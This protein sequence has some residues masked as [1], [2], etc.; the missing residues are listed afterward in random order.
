MTIDIHYTCDLDL[1]ISA[2]YTFIRLP[3]MAVTCLHKKI[4]SKLI[5]Q[6]NFIVINQVEGFESSFLIA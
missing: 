5:L 6:F 3:L 1:T 2:S 4:R